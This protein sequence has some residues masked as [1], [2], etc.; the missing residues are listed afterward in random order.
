MSK[1]DSVPEDV[2][3]EELRSAVETLAGVERRLAAIH[4]SLPISSSVAGEID[5]DL[6]VATEIRSVIDCVLTDSIRPAIRD[7]Q[8]AASYTGKPERR[9]PNREGS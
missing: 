5:D 3:R 7:L 1:R 6:D 9:R 8:A 2:A 4:Q